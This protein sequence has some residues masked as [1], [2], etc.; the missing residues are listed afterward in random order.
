MGVN[1]NCRWTPTCPQGVCKS[2]SCIYFDKGGNGAVLIAPSEAAKPTVEVAK[3]I[4]IAVM[5]AADFHSALS[6]VEKIISE[7]RNRDPLSHVNIREYLADLIRERK[8]VHFSYCL[9][10]RCNYSAQLEELAKQVLDLRLP[11]RQ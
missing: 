4:V 7:E 11:Y 9:S 1:L 6:F 5:Q 3:E 8:R 2:T 10:H